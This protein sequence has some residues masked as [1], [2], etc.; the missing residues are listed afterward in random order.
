M[1]YCSRMESDMNKICKKLIWLIFIINVIFSTS[2]YAYQLNYSGV[3]VMKNGGFEE[4]FFSFSAS[5]WV[6]QNC[7]FKRVKD[8][9]SGTYAAQVTTKSDDTS[10][11]KSLVELDLDS[12][13]EVSVYIKL[14]NVSELLESD[15]VCAR[16]INHHYT[17]YTDKNGDRVTGSTD[18][19]HMGLKF[20]DID[21]SGWQKISYVYT[22]KSWYSRYGTDPQNGNGYLYLQCDVFS[23]HGATG[24]KIPGYPITYLLDDFSVKKLNPNNINISG[25]KEIE[26]PEDET[27]NEYYTAFETIELESESCP[28]FEDSNVEISACI[29]KEGVSFSNGVLSV[30]PNAV[31]Q[32]VTLTATNGDI[33]STFEINIVEELTDSAQKYNKTELLKNLREA[34]YLYTGAQ[35]GNKTAFINEINEAY[36]VCA[37]NNLKFQE[38]YEA[39]KKLEQAIFDFKRSMTPYANV[40]V[41]AAAL[42]EGD[43]SVQNPFKTITDAKEYVR[44]ISPQMTGDIIVNIASGTYLQ[45]DTAQSFTPAD[46]GRNGFSVIY[47]GND[48]TVVTGGEEISTNV[49]S[50]YEN[51]IYRTNIGKDKTIRQLY[52]NDK[53][54]IR[55][56]S[57]GPIKNIVQTN[58]GY[59]TDDLTIAGFQRPLDVE[60]VYVNAWENPRATIKSVVR[61]ENTLNIT[62]N[63]TAWKTIG[64]YSDVNSKLLYY[65]MHMSFLMSRAN[66]I[67]IV[68]QDIYTICP[69]MVRT[70]LMLYIL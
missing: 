38:G 7:S 10:V 11:I 48:N 16:F 9:R 24:H 64:K 44:S 42:N 39:K 4:G 46:S 40:Y 23:N 61:N 47:R 66:G 53:R 52:V 31:E 35:S 12:W 6:S 56:R 21:S 41:D 58:E 14:L 54:A 32:T 33:N 19:E 26:I 59:T 63:E 18:V 29:P 37:K 65:E 2:T 60:L 70:K 67:I 22:P 13:Y 3:E 51:G 27:L 68:K 30:S 57:T 36:S 17:T 50:L 1:I 43:G 49:W 45:T 8:A 5:E 62:L 25:N 69:E 55:A 20:Y 28:I 34:I 15:S